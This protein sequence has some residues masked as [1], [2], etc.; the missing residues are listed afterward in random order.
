[1]HTRDAL[2]TITRFAHM[3][4]MGEL[5]RVAMAQTLMVEPPQGNTASNLAPESRKETPEWTPNI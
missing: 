3:P 5:Q 1:M 4:V 2:M